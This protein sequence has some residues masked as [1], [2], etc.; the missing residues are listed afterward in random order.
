[1]PINRKQLEPGLTALFD[2]HYMDYKKDL[3]HRVAKAIN[4][5]TPEPNTTYATFKSTE[6]Y[7]YGWIDPSMEIQDLN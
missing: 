3:S 7:L 5:S 6:R 4:K 1:M 2:A